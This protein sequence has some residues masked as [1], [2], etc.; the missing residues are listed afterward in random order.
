MRKKGRNTVKHLIGVQGHALRKG[1][2][3]DLNPGG[4]FE[5]GVLGALEADLPQRGGRRMTSPS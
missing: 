3:W 5:G 4:C 1:R 2:S